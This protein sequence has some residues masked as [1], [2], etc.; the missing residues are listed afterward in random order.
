MRYGELIGAMREA[1][2]RMAPVID[3]FEDQVLF[4]RHNLN[5]QAVVSLR[6]ELADIELETAA[7]IRAME[8]SIAQANQFISQMGQT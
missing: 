6:S 3:A 5:S 8:E 7:L 2:G 4:L 1:E